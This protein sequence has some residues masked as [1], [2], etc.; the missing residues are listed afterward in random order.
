MTGNS[1]RQ[2]ER[3]H[4]PARCAAAWLG[5]DSKV[6]KLKRFHGPEYAVHRGA[7]NVV[8]DS[9]ILQTNTGS[10][11]ER[12]EV[13]TI[14]AGSQGSTRVSVGPDAKAPSDTDILPECVD[15]IAC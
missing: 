2:K 12:V 1:L 15:G 13:G 5:R 9:K 8:G 6:F 7:G 4:T 11:T 3:P 10:A 14:F